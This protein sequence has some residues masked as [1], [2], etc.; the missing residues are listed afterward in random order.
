[1]RKFSCSWML[2]LSLVACGPGADGG[3]G[4]HPT[5][6]DHDAL[7][8]LPFPS[9]R[10]LGRDTQTRAD[11]D[12]RATGF[13]LR[14]APY[15]RLDPALLGAPEVAE[16]L[17]GLDGF[18]TSAEIAIGLTSA[19][20]ITAYTDALH[21]FE[22]SIAADSPLL[23]FSIDPDDPDVGT[24]LPWV[25]RFEYDGNVLFVRPARPLHAASWYAVVLRPGLRDV[26]GHPF[27]AP[28]AFIDRYAAAVTDLEGEGYARLRQVYADRVLYALTFRTASITAKLRDL[29]ADVRRLVPS[30]VTWSTRPP[31]PQHAAVEMLVEGW[32][33]HADYRDGKGKL[34]RQ[35]VREESI[36]FTLSLPKNTDAVREPFAVVLA[37]HGFGSHR[38]GMLALADEFARHGLALLTIDAP[39]HGA[40]GPGDGVPGDFLDGLR[41]SF[42]IGTDGNSLRIKGWFFR[43]LLRQQVLTQ[44]QLLR[45][46]DAW[47]GDVPRA[48]NLPGGDL[49]TSEVGYLGHSMGAVM[50]GVAG[51]VI[52]EFRRIV[53]NAGGGR[54]TDVFAHNAYIDEL[55]ILALRPR[56]VSRAD[57]WRVVNL[58]QTAIDPGDPINYATHIA[59]RPFAG[60]PPRPLLMQN[61]LGDFLVANHASFALARAV[62]ARLIGPYFVPTPGLLHATIRQHGFSGDD[63][64]LIS[65]F[66]EV[67]FG[68]AWVRADHGNMLVSDT[69]MRQ[70]AVFL[71]D[72]VVISP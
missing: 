7:R 12:E 58:L 47:Q 4:R 29:V 62:D 70:A 16:A 36:P 11:T 61:V 65:L 30:T 42:G 55:A 46:L 9:D 60:V 24:P 39:N 45:A 27:V 1:M 23:L 35:V 66:R 63:L 34:T 38:Q 32:F 28:S 50:G 18:G 67:R 48:G 19:P 33:T 69:G 72:G 64:A 21:A 53:L 71:A 3:L 54:I 56:G 6:V 51:A 17:A 31:Q 41:D 52:P 2:L 49:A 20:D 5:I 22:R 8:M 40:R 15:D 25:A 44:L 57:G 68:D 43:D 14:L 59:G 13:H 26:L 37:Q 10:F